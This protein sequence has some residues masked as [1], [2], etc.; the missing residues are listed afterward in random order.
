MWHLEILGRWKRFFLR[1]KPFYL[2]ESTND[3]LA[4]R[5]VLRQTDVNSCPPTPPLED[6]SYLVADGDSPKQ[7]LLLGG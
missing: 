3:E 4:V 6:V 5:R 1:K 7:A 2:T